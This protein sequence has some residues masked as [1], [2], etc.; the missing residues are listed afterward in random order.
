[1]KIT[2]EKDGQGFLAKVIGTD[3]LYAFGF[4]QQEAIK[5]LSNVIEMVADTY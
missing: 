4:T 1:M 3:E 5:E 2:I